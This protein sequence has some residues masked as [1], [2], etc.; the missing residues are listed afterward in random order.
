MTNSVNQIIPYN[1]VPDPLLD[2]HG[3]LGF[4]LETLNHPKPSFAQLITEWPNMKEK[5]YIQSAVEGEPLPPIKFIRGAEHHW[6]E[7]KD[8]DGH[9]G[10]L[11]VL[12]WNPGVKRWSHSGYVGSGI[13]VSTKDWV[14]HS[15]CPM[16][17]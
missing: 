1:H 16:P 17:D 11:V 4:D 12:Q 6:L 9:S 2:K 5:N 13:Y 3:T 7:K 14:Y 15:Q 10:G 8:C